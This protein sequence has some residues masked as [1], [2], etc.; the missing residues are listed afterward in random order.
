MSETVRIV[1]PDLRGHGE[2]RCEDEADL[3]VAHLLEDTAALLQQY[4]TAE[5]AT[6]M[7]L[8]GHSMGA[9]IAVRLSHELKAVAGVCRGIIPALNGVVVVEMVEGTALEAM[10][11][12]AAF[13]EDRP[14]TFASPEE[15]VEWSLERGIVRSASSAAISI[16]PQLT[17][18]ADGRWRW[19]TNVLKTRS[20]WRGWFTGLSQAFLSV[21]SPKLLVLGRHDVLSCDKELMIGQ[22]QGAFQLE[23]LLGGHLIQEDE[24]EQFAKQVSS[25]LL[26]Q[27]VTS[28]PNLAQGSLFC[29]EV[30]LGDE[31]KVLD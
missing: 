1:A 14:E 12:M 29:C 15:A 7:T 10:E 26:R 30:P 5:P 24:P 25:F 20:H 9:A 17:A 6:S 16:P 23:V 18:T 2:T 13:F 31:A 27:K 28:P 21:L 4:F 3:S 11:G 8:V 22:M 19:R